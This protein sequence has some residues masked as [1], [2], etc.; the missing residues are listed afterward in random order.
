LVHVSGHPRRDELKQLYK[1]VKPDVLVPVHGEPAHLVAHAELGKAEGIPIVLPARNGDLVRLFP[2]PMQFPGEVR[3]G[4][5][6]LDG[7]ILCSPEESGVKGR[8][9]LMFGGMVAVSLCIDREGHIKSGP[10]IHVEG[11]PEIEGEESVEDIVDKTVA[12]TI[13]GLH[14]RRRH[15]PDLLSET[16]RRAVRSELNAY[17]GRKPNVTIFVHQV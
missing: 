7:D 15:D 2:D 3:S 6:Y 5:L 10:D 12:T 8:R 9:R 14:A 11:L 17:W 13:R 1:W 16:I 4:R